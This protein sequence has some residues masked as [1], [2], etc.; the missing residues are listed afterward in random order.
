MQKQ[1]PLLNL[2]VNWHIKQRD[3]H[4][5]FRQSVRKGNLSIPYVSEKTTISLKLFWPSSC[6]N[7]PCVDTCIVMAFILLSVNSFSSRT[8]GF[9]KFRNV[10]AERSVPR[11]LGE[12]PYS[13]GNHKMALLFIR[14]YRKSIV[15]SSNSFPNLFYL[16][17]S[18]NITLK[19][20]D[21]TLFHRT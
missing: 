7:V 9:Q 6:L 10:W 13:Q 3:C 8:L 12:S 15:L 17:E 2:S 16:P 5:H 4:H 21:S 19:L 18:F 11:S 20:S 1:E 14:I